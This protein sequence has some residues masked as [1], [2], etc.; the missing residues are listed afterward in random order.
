MIVNT[1][2]RCEA[3]LKISSEENKFSEEFR[4]NSWRQNSFKAIK[5]V[6]TEK[7]KMRLRRATES[8]ARRNKPEDLAA[9]EARAFHW[10]ARG[11]TANAELGRV[12]F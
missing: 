3:I 9:L 7:T 4:G 10:I 12:F 5:R 2:E 11:R 6:T 8:I 1:F